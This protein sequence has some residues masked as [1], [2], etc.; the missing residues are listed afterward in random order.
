[1]RILA[2]RGLHHEV[3]EN[4]LESFRAAARL[5]VDGIE[6]DIRRTRDG[7]LILHHDRCLE[8]R[9]AISDLTVAEIEAALGRP[10]LTLEQALGEV[11][12]PLW[13]L[14]MKE[15]SGR[16]EVFGLL[17]REP[18][19]SGE[20]VISSF[21]HRGLLEAVARRDELPADLRISFAALMAHGPHP[22]TEGM[23]KVLAGSGISTV[24]FELGPLSGDTVREAR[25][26]G[27]DV[28]VY[29]AVTDA[30]LDWCQ[31]QGVEGVI[32]DHPEEFL[33]RRGSRE[34]DH[35]H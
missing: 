27:L 5:G 15:W 16:D 11:E 12:L 3:A 7:V 8:D 24:V 29:G 28:W 33:E 18:L 13:N 25:D 6:T 19:P 1:M 4:S 10:L 9:R 2:H 26:A 34:A 20:F 31:E 17:A 30:D 22:H 32:T 23:L 35:D 14:E 21:E